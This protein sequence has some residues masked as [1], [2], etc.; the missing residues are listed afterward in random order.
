MFKRP[1]AYMC[2]R[3]LN[4]MTI[5]KLC[6]LPGKVMKTESLR[7]DIPQSDAKCSVIV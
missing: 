7:G 3:V 2:R 1:L 4:E 6:K 5:G